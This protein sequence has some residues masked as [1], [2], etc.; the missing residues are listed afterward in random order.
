MVAVILGSCALFLLAILSS[1]IPVFRD[2]LFREGRIGTFLSV[3]YLT[4]DAI[5]CAFVCRAIARHGEQWPRVKPP[6]VAYTWA[7]CLTIGAAVAMFWAGATF[8]DRNHFYFSGR[9]L[10]WL[11]W[12]LVIVAA[13][14]GTAACYRLKTCRSTRFWLLFSGLL[15]WIALDDLLMFHENAAKWIN[16]TLL[17]L[18][19][20][21]PIAVHTND[22]LVGCYGLIAIALAWAYRSRLVH[23]PWMIFTMTL[24]SVFFIGTVWT[25]FAEAPEWQEECLKILAGATILAAL[26]TAWL[27]VEEGKLSHSAPAP[28]PVPATE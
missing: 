8:H 9:R 11:F 21:H 5:V 6:L 14:A 26:I 1:T 20:R 2:R 24:G 27:E 17:H 23:L 16:Q 3:A 12:G 13:A 18:P 4:S 28:P 10:G 22:A 15:G 25:D 19:E 7:L